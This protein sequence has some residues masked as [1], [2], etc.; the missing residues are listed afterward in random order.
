MCNKTQ[1]HIYKESIFENKTTLR[2]QLRFKSDLHVVYTEEINKIAISSN[3]DKRLQAFDK[4]TTYPYGTN[5]YKVCDSE[6]M[7]L[8][9]INK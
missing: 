7:A 4:V 8:K 6:M 1:T 2:S 9:N 5:A 3:D